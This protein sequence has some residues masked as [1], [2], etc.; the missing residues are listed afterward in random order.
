MDHYHQLNGL[1]TS[2]NI[3][4][5][6]GFYT[7]VVLHNSPIQKKLD[8]NDRVNPPLLTVYWLHFDK[9]NAKQWTSHGKGHAY[10]MKQ[11]DEK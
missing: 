4:L 3:K 10:V 6:P 9:D 8:I 2:D 5:S 7:I 11:I 1:K